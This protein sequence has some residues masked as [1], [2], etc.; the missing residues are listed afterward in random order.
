VGLLSFIVIFTVRLWVRTSKPAFGRFF[1][2]DC[3]GG[4][5][6]GGGPAHWGVHWL[7]ARTLH[8]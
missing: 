8:K 4:G 5:G 7:G 2:L 3:G 1:G 6:G